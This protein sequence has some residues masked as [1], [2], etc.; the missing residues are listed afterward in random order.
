M[1]QYSITLRGILY[2][3]AY[4]V[5]RDHTLFYN[6]IFSRDWAWRSLGDYVAA[7]RLPGRVVRCG[8]C[9]RLSLPSVTYGSCCDRSTLASKETP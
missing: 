3:K 1:K 2:C 8:N 4:K 7:G 9:Q 6:C 5:G